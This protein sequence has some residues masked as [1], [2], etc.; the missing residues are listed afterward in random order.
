[1]IYEAR[2]F[3]DMTQ[4]EMAEELGWSAKHVSNLE[5]ERRTMQKQTELA[6]ECL[7]RRSGGW[8]KFKKEQGYAHD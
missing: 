7:I 4:A 8:N 1:M 3:L 2:Q 5:V 6:I